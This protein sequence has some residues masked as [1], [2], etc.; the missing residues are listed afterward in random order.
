MTSV[1]LECGQTACALRQDGKCVEGVADPTDC[2]FTFEVEEADADV[3]GEDEVAYPDG[4]D[5]E[6]DDDDVGAIESD[7]AEIADQRVGIESHDA[8]TLA[9]AAAL[10]AAE[11]TRVVLVAGE[12]ESGKTTLL[13]EMYA[14]FL[15]G[16]L[17]Q[18]WFAG[19]RSIGGF[20]RRHKPARASSGSRVPTTERTTDEDLR[21]LHIRLAGSEGP[22]DLLFSDLP[23]EI[24]E[25]IIEGAKVADELPF[26]GRVDVCLL[27]VDGSLLTTASGRVLAS[28][29]AR[30]LIGALVHDG[31]L[32]RGAKV[33]VV[34]TKDDLLK[35]ASQR[36]ADALLDSLAEWCGER[37]ESRPEILK[38]SAR[39]LA[40]TPGYGL[41]R[42]LDWI[43]SNAS[44]SSS[45]SSRPHTGRFFWRGGSN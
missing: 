45:E 13:V 6:E 40:G 32:R 23:G 27:I 12:V 17:G 38:V 28:M 20:H 26:I 2:P 42:L 24:F 16:P 35:E 37:G 25:N 43:G 8:L 5:F 30:Q 36:E 22:I 15:E 39:P 33:A 41:D 21:H 31:A 1:A 19:S 9:E 34:C 11:P 14:R 3:A 29:R 10:A 4:D 18:W 7:D 44:E